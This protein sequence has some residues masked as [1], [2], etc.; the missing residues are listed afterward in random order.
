MTTDVEAWRSAG[1]SIQPALPLSIFYLKFKLS[2]S[3]Q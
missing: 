1:H 2:Y 3:A